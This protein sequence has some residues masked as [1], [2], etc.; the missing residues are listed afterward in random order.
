MAVKIKETVIFNKS[1]NELF[2][3]Y[4]PTLGKNIKAK[5]AYYH[6]GSLS[7]ELY[8]FTHDHQRVADLLK[9]LGR[10]FDVIENDLYLVELPT[11]AG[12]SGKKGYVVYLDSN[13]HEVV[14]GSGTESASDV[15]STFLGWLY[16]DKGNND[17]VAVVKLAHPYI[18]FVI[19]DG[20][21]ALAPGTKIRPENNTSAV[22][23]YADTRHTRWTVDNTNYVG[24]VLADYGNVSVLI[25]TT[26]S[27][28]SYDNSNRLVLADIHTNILEP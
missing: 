22:V 11:S 21:S 26:T 3:G 19:V 2:F 7:E 8:A 1:N 5:Q 20:S 17:T 16:K 28:P 10:N 12:W 15:A 23:P 25:D 6:I 24:V 14:L 9:E 13:T 4:L 18:D 27:P